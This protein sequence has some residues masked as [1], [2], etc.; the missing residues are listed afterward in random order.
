MHI[1]AYIL[2]ADPA[3]LE[4]SVLSYYHLVRKIVV[5]YDEAHLS[6]SGTPIPVEE[7]LRR[8]RAIDSESKMV[9]IPGNF[10]RRAYNPMQND[11]Y[12]RQTALDL[13]SDDADWVLQL[14][15]DEVLGNPGAFLSCL[16]T[17][18]RIGFGAMEY[19]ARWLYASLGNNRYL[20]RCSPLWQTVAGF[21]GPVAIRPGNTLYTSRQCD[22]T[23]YR[24]DF[25][26]RNTDP[27]HS[28]D[29]PVH[30][31]V[32]ERDGIIHYSWIRD[33]SQLRRK[34]T[35]WG[36]SRDD[37]SPEIRHWVWAGKHPILASL[38]TPFRRFPQRMRITH[39]PLASA[40]APLAETPRHSPSIS[41]A[42]PLGKV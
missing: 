11:T 32:A 16:K 15:T 19:P 3:W 37:W 10:A 38:T 40:Q 27:F 34:T 1:N 18:H 31:V 5:S 41:N 20:E 29:A 7:C 22:T 13:A 17:A 8:L 36:H 12:Q 4:S 39:I 6:W 9:F 21:P 24:V 42:V 35:A 26:K 2:A 14:D 25:R 33:E 23:L 30:A 28:P